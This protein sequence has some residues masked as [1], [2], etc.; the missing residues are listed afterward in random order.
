[1]ILL[2]FIIYP[3]DLRSGNGWIHKAVVIGSMVHI[4]EEMQVF[5]DAQ[6]VENLI[7]SKRQVKGAS[8]ST[9]Y[10]WMGATMNTCPVPKYCVERGQQANMAHI[11]LSVEGPNQASWDIIVPCPASFSQTS[12]DA[13]H[14]DRAVNCK[15]S[16][17][18]ASA[19]EAEDAGKHSVKARLTPCLAFKSTHLECRC[20]LWHC[21]L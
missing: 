10:L 19:T 11:L 8:D 21:A 18:L 9:I 20:V 16:H 17:L 15:K 1:M 6:P 5:R 3:F 2:I 7:I 13:K 4:I 14:P 12:Y